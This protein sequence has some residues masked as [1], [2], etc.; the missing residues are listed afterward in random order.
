MLHKRRSGEEAITVQA[1]LRGAA[2]K[3]IVS[4]SKGRAAR[5]KRTGSRDK[6]I[7][8]KP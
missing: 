3:E 5:R 8:K 4:S 6:E 7:M 1:G 2:A